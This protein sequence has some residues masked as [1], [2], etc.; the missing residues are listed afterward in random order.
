METQNLSMRCWCNDGASRE[1]L[2]FDNISE[3]VVFL[4]L[5]TMFSKR[6]RKHVRV[7]VKLQIEKLMKVWENSKKL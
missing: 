1:I 6:N 5:V 4:F 3:Q 7:S 2:D